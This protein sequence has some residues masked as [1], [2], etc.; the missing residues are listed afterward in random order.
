[1]E[2][3]RP[4][5]PWR[6]TSP[7]GIN[8]GREPKTGLQVSGGREGR[9]KLPAPFPMKGTPRLHHPMKKA[10]PLRSS[11]LPSKPHSFCSS[12]LSLGNHTG[13]LHP[14]QSP[15]QPFP[16]K[17]RPPTIPSSLLHLRK[18]PSISQ[19]FLGSTCS[20]EPPPT[21]LSQ[22][23][24]CHQPWRHHQPRDNSDNSKTT[25]LRPASPQPG[26]PPPSL[27]LPQRK[28]KKTPEINS[29]TS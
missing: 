8:G 25:L 21:H 17:S 26:D 14:E 6:W 19:T 2:G 4:L 5:F 18:P 13:R 11:S 9:V 29:L 1:M 28:K 12:S 10:G 24:T 3:S 22:V 16:T 23:I 20:I 15:G 27:R 7:S